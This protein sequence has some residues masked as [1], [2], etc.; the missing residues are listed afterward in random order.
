MALGT[1]VWEVRPG[2]GSNNNGGGFAV[3][4]TGTDYSQQDSPQYA[5]SDLISISSLVIASASHNFVS[6]D[7]GNLININSGTSFTAGIY[8]VISVAANQATLDRS[9]GTVG[10]SGVWKLGGAHAT[11]ASIVAVGTLN[12]A[13]IYVKATGTLTLTAASGLNIVAFTLIGYTTTRTDGGQATI[14]TATNSVDMFLT[15]NDRIWFFQNLIFTNTASTRGKCVS[16][17]GGDIFALVLKNCDFDGFTNAIG[18]V[19][20]VLH[21][22]AFG[23]RVKNS[24]GAGLS[25][26]NIAGVFYDCFIHDNTAEGVL[27]GGAA[28]TNVT[29]SNCVIKSNTYGVKADGVQLI[30]G[31]YFINCVVINNSAD[32]IYSKHSANSYNQL[33][34]LVNTDVDSAGAVGVTLT[35]QN[36][37]PLWLGANNAFWNNTTSDRTSGLAALPGDVTLTGDPFTSRSTADFSL[38]ATAGAGAAM[39]A[40][41]FPQTFP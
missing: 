27:I 36:S 34:M 1:M 13:M 18:L 14:T 17:T 9:P 28:Q 22:A 24:T 20:N 32:N 3:G 21:F 2:V 39:K 23:V 8:Q 38:N 19:N 4:G 29:F 31:L 25:F 12:A 16:S 11:F 7:V 15:A 35:Y 33:L 41:G 30:V 37:F 5:F 26:A 10:V 40:A 6:A